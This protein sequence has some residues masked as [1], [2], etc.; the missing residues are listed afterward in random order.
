MSDALQR[1]STHGFVCGDMARGMIDRAGNKRFAA[2]G[3]LQK[4]GGDVRRFAC[5]GVAPMVVTTYRTCDDFA[6]GD[7]DVNGQR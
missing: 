1:L 7:T 6:R 5:D 4:S 2:G 3:S